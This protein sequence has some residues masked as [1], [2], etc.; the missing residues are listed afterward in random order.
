MQISSAKCQNS[1]NLA[2]RQFAGNRD[3]RHGVR[4]PLFA[5][6]DLKNGDVVGYP[7]P[8]DGTISPC[9]V[10]FLHEMYKC[11]PAQDVNDFFEEGPQTR[12]EMPGPGTADS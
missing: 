4:D 8:K 7:Q 9:L 12:Q 11:D 6:I 3:E 5:F 10:A 1:G 2:F